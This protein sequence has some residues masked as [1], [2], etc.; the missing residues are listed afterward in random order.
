M[1]RPHL[2]CTLLIN[3]SNLAAIFYFQKN[4]EGLTLKLMGRMG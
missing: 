1:N 2:C 4:A 3:C